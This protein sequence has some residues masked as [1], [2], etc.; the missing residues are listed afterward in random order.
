MPNI[1]QLYAQLHDKGFEIVGISLD[2][3]DQLVE[4][5]SKQAGMTWRQIVDRQSVE[6]LRERYHVRTIPS[7]YIL[8]KKGTISQVDV[9]G[10]DLRRTV[11]ELLEK[12]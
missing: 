6:T 10:R 1:K 7:L 5:F 3:D 9:K 12:E 4:Q 2:G 11:T 8:D